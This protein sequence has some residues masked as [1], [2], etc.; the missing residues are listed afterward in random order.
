MNPQEKYF[1]LFQ[2]IMNQKRKSAHA[3]SL[4]IK[5]KKRRDHKLGKLVVEDKDIINEDLY[6]F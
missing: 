5:K 4:K 1:F 6:D 3:E 2:I